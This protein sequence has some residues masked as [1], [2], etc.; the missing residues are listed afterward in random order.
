MDV[1]VINYPKELILEDLVNDGGKAVNFG[2]RIEITADVCLFDASGIFSD[3]D[4]SA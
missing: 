3:V 1:D 2:V 4:R